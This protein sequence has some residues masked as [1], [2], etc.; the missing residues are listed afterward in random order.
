MKN[1]SCS[2]KLSKMNKVERLKKLSLIVPQVAFVV[3]TPGSKSNRSVQSV[4]LRDFTVEKTSDGNHVVKGRNIADEAKLD[5]KKNIS[6][7]LM[8]KR[9]HED[10]VIKS[11]RVDRI[12]NGS[13]IY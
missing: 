3:H 2:E 6:M 7:S 11:Y 5:L 9:E 1:C 4:I 12:L 13:I 10:C 8:K